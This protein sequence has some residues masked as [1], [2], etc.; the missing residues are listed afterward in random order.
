MTKQKNCTTNFKKEKEEEEAPKI[1]S[2]NAFAQ[3][4]TGAAL[5]LGCKHFE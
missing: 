3:Q 1:P 5:D 4:K 2:I